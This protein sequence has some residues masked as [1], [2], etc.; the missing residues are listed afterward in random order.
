MK[1]NKSSFPWAKIILVFILTTSCI[2]ICSCNKSEKIKR[3]K[4]SGVNVSMSL[5]DAVKGEMK[6]VYYNG[7]LVITLDDGKEVDALCKKEMAENLKGGQMLEIEY[8]DALKN[9]VVKKIIE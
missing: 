6:D 5:S 3:G 4:L 1:Q 2:F 9:W 7:T 8:D